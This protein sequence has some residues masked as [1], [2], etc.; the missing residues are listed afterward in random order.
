MAN[1]LDQL[2]AMTTIDNKPIISI[3]GKSIATI[4]TIN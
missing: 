2:K 4:R 3:K 1:L